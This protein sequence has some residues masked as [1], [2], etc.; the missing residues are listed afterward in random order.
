MKSYLAGVMGV[1]V[2][3][4]GASDQVEG[5]VV[6]DQAGVGCQEEIGKGLSY[7]Y[8][9]NISTGRGIW[10][11]SNVGDLHFCQSPAT[12]NRRLDMCQTQ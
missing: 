12:G 3:G 10:S 1:E 4:G 5:V 11:G 2:F 8:A 6:E 9:N 7:Q